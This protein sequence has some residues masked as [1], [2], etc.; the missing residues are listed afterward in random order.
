MLH[1]VVEHVGAQPLERGRQVGEVGDGRGRRTSA[2]HH[3]G[4]CRQRV[5]I[6]VEYR[7]ARHRGRGRAPPARPW[8]RGSR[9]PRTRGPAPVPGPRRCGGRR[10]R[11]DASGRP[12]TARGTR[13]CGRGWR[14]TSSRAS[15]RRDPRDGRGRR[16]RSAGRRTGRRA[17]TGARVVT[18]R[19]SGSPSSAFTR[20]QATTRPA[21]R[22]GAGRPVRR[23]AARPNASLHESSTSS[24]GAG[25]SG[26][27][28]DCTCA[29]GSA[30]WNELSALRMA[31]IACARDDT[32]CGK[33]PAVADPVDLVSNRL[34]DGHPDG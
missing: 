33:A 3:F 8:P 21:P 27:S 28:T 24:S 18:R 10:S 16:R 2:H 14:R 12:A 34:V 6:S 11:T 4:T 22:G 1:R 30:R 19:S 31:P 13:S 9:R 29:A 23:D 17:S 26:I 32:S 20:I 5:H 7:Q 25:T 15:P